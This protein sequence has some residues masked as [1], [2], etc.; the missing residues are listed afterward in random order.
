M[1]QYEKPV[2]S[3]NWEGGE[4][5]ENTRREEEFMYKYMQKRDK[6]GVQNKTQDGEQ[7]DEDDE[8]SQFAEDEIKKEMDRLQSGKGKIESDEED[9][10]V[11]YS[12]S[13]E[14]K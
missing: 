12:S 6:K 14:E 7:I 13:E 3:F 2:N 10:D 11:D 8:I 5:P 4:R 1:S 9:L